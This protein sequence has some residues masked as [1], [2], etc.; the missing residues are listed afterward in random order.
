M[1]ISDWSSDVCSSDLIANVAAAIVVGQLGTAVARPDE[2]L[3]ALPAQELLAAE[4]K[5]ADL[6]SLV[7]PVSRWRQAGPK[8]GFTNGCFHLPHPCTRHLL[9]TARHPR[10]P[11]LFRP[12]HPPPTPN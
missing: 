6:D 10:Q 9:D 2:I 5:V 1:R 11:P 12:Q 8:V 3:H 4:A 7:T